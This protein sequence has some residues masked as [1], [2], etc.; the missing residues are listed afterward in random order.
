MVT[1][2]GDCAVS[3]RGAAGLRAASLLFQPSPRKITGSAIWPP[4]KAEG[5][6]SMSSAIKPRHRGEAINGRTDLDRCDNRSHGP[7][8][9]SSGE[10]R[11]V[12]VRKIEMVRELV[13]ASNCRMFALPMWILTHDYSAMLELTIR[14]RPVIRFRMRRFAVESCQDWAWWAM[15]VI[16]GLMLVPMVR[17]AE[18]KPETLS[19]WERYIQSA[20]TAM[21]ARPSRAMLFCGRMKQRA[22]ASGSAREKFW[23]PSVGDQTPKK[24]PVRADPSLD[25][26]RIFS[27]CPAGGCAQRGPRLRAL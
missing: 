26:R 18:L 6:D 25:R 12:F 9:G 17:A 20:D 13:R 14:E 23:W 8:G 10:A 3:E 4:S 21:H 11:F 27:E 5:I 19:A 1:A 24:R 16:F 22:G 15:P 2:A 7:S